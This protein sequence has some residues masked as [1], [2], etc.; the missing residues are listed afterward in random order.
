MAT[1]AG[2]VTAAFEREHRFF[3]ITACIMALVLVAGFSTS[4]AFGRSSFVKNK[5]SN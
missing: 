3:F 4:L 5:S 1:R 2:S